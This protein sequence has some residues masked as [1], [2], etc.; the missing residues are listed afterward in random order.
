MS[1]KVI[2]SW[3]TVM[4]LAVLAAW[5][6]SLEGAGH[7]VRAFVSMLIG[8]DLVIS[9]VRA[10]RRLV[11]RDKRFY[12]RRALV[13]GLGGV[14]TQAVSLTMESPASGPEGVAVAFA[15]VFGLVFW[16]AGSWA[17]S[18]L[19]ALVYPARHAA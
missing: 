17:A 11:L 6:G 7:G 13:G 15:L 12:L 3:I 14:V 18:K 1:N 10:S 9:A 4:V 16:A 8:G 19:I 5:V 2:W